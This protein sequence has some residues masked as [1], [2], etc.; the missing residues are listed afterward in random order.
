MAPAPDA[1]G[2]DEA[3]GR[4]ESAV[5]GH[6]DHARK[7]SD[8]LLTDGLPCGAR[9][10]RP[11]A[12]GLPQSQKL[13]EFLE[14]V[15]QPGGYAHRAGVKLKAGQ[16]IGAKFPPEEFH[17]RIYQQF[18]HAR[19]EG[20]DGRT[21]LRNALSA[22]HALAVLLD[23]E[24][25]FDEMMQEGRAL[26]TRIIPLLRLCWPTPASDAVLRTYRGPCRCPPCGGK[27]PHIPAVRTSRGVSGERRPCS[28]SHASR[29]R[30]ERRSCPP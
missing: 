24:D 22:K 2:R 20:L 25:R 29:P 21:R 4:T 17:I 28:L 26:P 1:R 7:R 27:F 13:H 14:G 5:R 12:S 8:R 19:R 23:R 9:L 18:K 11:E 6:R 10:F 3:C 30:A 16:R 15:G